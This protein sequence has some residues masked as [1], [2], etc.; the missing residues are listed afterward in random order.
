ME[1]TCSG[2]VMSRRSSGV[3]ARNYEQRGNN[4]TYEGQ[5]SYIGGI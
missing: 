3:T 1:G 5:H 2:L 4:Q